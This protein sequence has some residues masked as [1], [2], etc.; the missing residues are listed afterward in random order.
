MCVWGGGGGG[1]WGQIIA[2]KPYYSLKQSVSVQPSP[3][4]FAEEWGAGE[5]GGGEGGL[6]VAFVVIF[7]IKY[8]PEGN[9]SAQ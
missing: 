1:N 4:L 7:C 2:Y 3:S 8:L 9:Q 6:M 5:R